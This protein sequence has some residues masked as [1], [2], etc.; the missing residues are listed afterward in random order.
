MDEA[1][2]KLVSVKD[3]LGRTERERKALERDLGEA[4]AEIERARRVVAES[5]R[6]REEAREELET[7]RVMSAQGFLEVRQEITRAR[8]E[9]AEEVHRARAEVDACRAREQAILARLGELEETLRLL[10]SGLREEEERLGELEEGLRTVNP[11]GPSVPEA[12]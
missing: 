2:K 6:A 10:A 5:Q 1:S 9:A 11:G 4:R 3:E 8:E 12:P 7:I